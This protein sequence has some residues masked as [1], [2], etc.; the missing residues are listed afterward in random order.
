VQRVRAAVPPPGEALPDHVM[1]GRL[2]ARLGYDGLS[3]ASAEAIFDEM[4]SLSPI[5]SAMSYARIEQAGGLCWPC[6]AEHPD[7]TPRLHERGFPI[8]RARMV[9][10]DHVGPVELPDASYPL[11]L[12][13]TRLGFHYGCGSMTRKS[14]L[15]ERETPRGLLYIH[16]H[17]AAR[18][19]LVQGSPVSVGSRRGE[20]QT[21]AVLSD[22]VPEGVV[23]MPYHFREAPCNLV[24]NDAQDPVT[25]MPELK[26][27]A[28]R[29]EPRGGVEPGPRS[30]RPPGGTTPERT[31]RGEAEP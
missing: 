11:T 5:Y 13:T 6:D 24:T 23:A 9:P 28:V 21:A 16:P 14:P 2:A 22:E 20:V 25:R 31:D 19:H 8:G 17:D 4:A 1:L 29:V 3:Y 15:L 27:C 12:T 18:L 30:Q 26:V 10:L 7:G